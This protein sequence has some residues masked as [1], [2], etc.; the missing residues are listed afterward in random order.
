MRHIA[1]IGG[2]GF[3]VG[4]FLEKLAGG[5]VELLLDLRQRRGVRG[6]GYSRANSARRQ[7]ALAAAD[8][9][10]RHV[11]ELAPTTELRH[12]QYREDDRQCVGKR[13][14]IAA[15]TRARRTLHP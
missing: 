13:N 14:R 3:T 12:V 15:G 1:T 4:A 10:Y 9:G 7:R 8:I 6:P 5:G 2:Y 11:K